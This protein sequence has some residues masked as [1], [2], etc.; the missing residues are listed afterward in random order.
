MPGIG[1]SQLALAYARQEFRSSTY[2]LIIWLSGTTRDKI[3]EGLKGALVLLEH[4]AR[5]EKD[6]N[7][8]SNAF[9]RWL[10]QCPDVGCKRWL[11]IVDNLDASAL[12]VLR[13][14]IPN[15]MRNGDLLITTRREAVANSML[16]SLEEPIELLALNAD[17]AAAF[18]LERARIP[19][20]SGSQLR[21]LL[22]I[23]HR[24]GCHPL[25]LEQAGAMIEQRKGNLQMLQDILCGGSYSAVRIKLNC[26]LEI[27]NLTSL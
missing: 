3:M 9:Q 21:E 7:A 25:A 16:R 27:I 24:L 26:M 4:P 12:Q 18:L 8:I 1:K 15:D 5:A 10:E 2:D 6:E 22:D 11:I 19:N 13:Q 23:V 17:N 20:S 14:N